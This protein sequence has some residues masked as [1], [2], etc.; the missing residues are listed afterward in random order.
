LKLDNLQVL[1]ERALLN[2]FMYSGTSLPF[3]GMV[4]SIVH[5]KSIKGWDILLEQHLEINIVQGNLRLAFSELAFCDIWTARL[6]KTKAGISL[7]RPLS[8][9]SERFLRGGGMIPDAGA[10]VALFEVLSMESGAAHVGYKLQAEEEESAEL[11][12]QPDRAC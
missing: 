9:M 2:R 11:T 5:T 4:Q 3:W 1:E 12:E 10:L 6:A 8:R 7:P